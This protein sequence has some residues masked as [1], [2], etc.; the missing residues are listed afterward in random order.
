MQT[1]KKGK[2][3]QEEFANTVYEKINEEWKSDGTV[4]M[5]WNVMKS[6]LCENT[7]DVPGSVDKRQSDWFRDSEDKLTLFIVKRNR[8]YFL[9]LSSG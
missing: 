5:K 4:E 1:E 9:L 3:I 6:A 7:S 8:M 2:T